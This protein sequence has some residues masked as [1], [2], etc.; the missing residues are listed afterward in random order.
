MHC[1]K[2]YLFEQFLNDKFI[3]TRT[4]HKLQPIVI[5]NVLSRCRKIENEL[6]INLDDFCGDESSLDFLRHTIYTL[7]SKKNNFKVPS[8][9][10]YAI[11]LY[12]NFSKNS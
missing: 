7:N 4:G 1:M 3:S 12:Y 9:Y 11:N 10:I 6:Q 2:K 5:S 8:V